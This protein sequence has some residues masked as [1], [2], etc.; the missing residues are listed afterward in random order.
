MKKMVETPEFKAEAAK[1]GMEP[2]FLFGDDF[3]KFVNKDAEES[4]ALLKELGFV[5]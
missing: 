5:K 2:I 3:A 4:R 1:V